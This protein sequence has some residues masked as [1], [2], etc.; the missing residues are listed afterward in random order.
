MSIHVT[1]EDAIPSFYTQNNFVS[2]FI[3]HMLS[4]IQTNMKTNSNKILR[5][6]II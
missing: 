6:N 1:H 2:F 3:G 4:R 5:S